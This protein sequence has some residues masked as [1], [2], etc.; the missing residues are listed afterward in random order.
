MKKFLLLIVAVLSLAS[1]SAGNQNANRELSKDELKNYEPMARDIVTAFLNK[2]FE[3][4]KE[5]SDSNMKDFFEDT[6]NLDTAYEM[7]DSDGE[8]KKFLK[9]DGIFTEESSTY[10]VFQ[11]VQFNKTKR[12]FTIR[13]NNDKKLSGLFIK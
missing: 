4:L 2:D 3:I 11:E 6:K 8:F 13:F 7:I 9:A 12:M 1:C 5:R 10:T